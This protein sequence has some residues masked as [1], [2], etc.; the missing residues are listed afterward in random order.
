MST[1]VMRCNLIGYRIMKQE[2]LEAT[3][4][5][6]RQFSTLA[7]DCETAEERE[8]YQDQ[9]EREWLDRCRS[10]SWYYLDRGLPENVV[11]HVFRVITGERFYY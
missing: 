9:C 10:I 4:Q 5:I 6:C 3:D 1:N 7:A 2:L 8:L 11:A